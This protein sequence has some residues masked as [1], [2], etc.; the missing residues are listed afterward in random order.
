MTTNM[1]RTGPSW[2]MRHQNLNEGMGGITGWACDLQ[3]A[4][5]IWMY[6]RFNFE[7]FCTADKGPELAR[8]NIFSVVLLVEVKQIPRCEPM[9]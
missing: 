9:H 7:P 5:A 1:P 3:A 6:D 2:V 4:A 8:K